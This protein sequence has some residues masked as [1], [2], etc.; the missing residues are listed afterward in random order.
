MAA[1]W[2]GRQYLVQRY[3]TA[4]ITLVGQP[5]A[6]P[7]P[8]AEQILGLGTSAACD[9]GDYHFPTLPGV[10]RELTEIIRQPGETTG[11]VPGLRLI[12]SA[13]TKDALLSKLESHQYPLAHVASHFA[14]GATDT[15]SYLLLGDG[16]EVSVSELRAIPN[17]LQGVD[18][19]TLSACDTAEDVT[20]H[21]GHEIDGF[22]AL[23]QQMGARSVLASLW[24]VSDDVTPSLMEALYKYRAD[25]PGAGTGA[26]LRVAQLSLLA[27]Q[28]LAVPPSGGT[29]ATRRGGEPTRAIALAAQPVDSGAPPFTPDPNAPY[30]H[31]FYWAP[32]ILI[33]NWK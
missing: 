12:N 7:A 25:N 28:A 22:G 30:A 5:P 8:T 16:S 23:M 26:A 33:R 32:F 6:A 4:A 3:E 21:D 20:V 15:S 17:V 2:D 14:I 31:P 11:L 27:P 10:S 18:L 1:L 9:V 19:L 13:F 24:P 29:T